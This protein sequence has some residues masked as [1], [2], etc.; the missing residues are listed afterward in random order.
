MIM[1]SRVS[2]MNN[3]IMKQVGRLG[4][5]R[6]HVSTLLPYLTMRKLSNLILNIIEHR[7]VISSPRSLP[8]YV[9]IEPTP[10]CQ[11]RCTGCQQSEDNFT[12]TLRHDMHMPV[13]RFRRILEPL[14]PTLM[15]VSLSY[16]GEPLLGRGILDMIECAHELG[17]AVSFPSNLSMPITAQRAERLVKSGVDT[18]Y[19][20]LDGAS[21]RTYEIYRRGGRFDLVLKNVALLAE[22]KCRLGRARPRL[23]WKFVAFEHNRHEMPE[24]KQR[25]RQY[26]FDSYEIVRDVD[27][28]EIVASKR[29]RFKDLREKRRGCFWAWNTLTVAENGDV[30]PCCAVDHS[31]HSLGNASAGDILSI[32][33]GAAYTGLRQAF[34]TGKPE[35]MFPSC[36]RCLGHRARSP[37]T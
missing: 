12:A 20:S 18:I 2:G 21:A 16:R 8:P 23:I 7:L 11:L 34:R 27:S 25:Y 31:G 32:W 17:V 3:M 10:L 28:A 15:G 19:I 1:F 14:A 33:R 4:Y 6:R 30:H 5:F 26:G 13:D 9:K 22:T 24:V 36:A 37:A 35:E 29:R